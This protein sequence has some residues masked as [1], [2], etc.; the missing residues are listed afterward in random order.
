MVMVY[1]LGCNG[2]EKVCMFSEHNW[3]PEHGW[4]PP[5]PNIFSHNWLNL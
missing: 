4:I 5:S 3:V 2:M 1:C